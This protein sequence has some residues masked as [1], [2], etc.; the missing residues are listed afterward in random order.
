MIS[1][2]SILSDVELEARLARLVGRERAVATELLVHLAEFDAR[3]LYLGAGFS[4]LFTYCC[5]VL[6]LSE[7]EAY[8]RIE[9]ARAVRKFPQVLELLRDGSLSLT[10]ARM[11]A[12][13]LTHENAAALLE[14]ASGKSKRELEEVLAAQFPRPAVEASVR[15]L[16]AA[17]AVATLS[18]APPPAMPLDGGE[19]QPT[20]EAPEPVP[21]S[22][23]PAEVAP[24]SADQFLVKFTAS[25]CTREKLR[26]AQDLLR[27]T[28]PS[29]DVAQII[30][31]ALTLLLADL[32][33]KKVAA[34]DR[35][36][37]SKG[38]ARG[39]RHVPA[40]VK[41]GSWARDGGRCAFVGRT[42]RRCNERA[43]VEFHHVDPYVLDGTASLDGI[44]LRCRAHNQY[45][46]TLYFG[47]RLRDRAV[48]PERPDDSVGDNLRD[49]PSARG[50]VEI[51]HPHSADGAIG[52]AGAASPRPMA[53]VRR[54]VAANC[55][56]TADAAGT[57]DATTHHPL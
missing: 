29:G 10:T 26:Q 20:A 45:E 38:P 30:D 22:A 46:A 27:H 51:R 28:I 19:R 52:G 48:L 15:K 11:L 9:A 2:L 39:S 25:A 31:R 50:Y 44:G 14:L 24:L 49:T 7:G 56:D 34:T 35:P 4:S 16:P 21:R 13:H 41:R 53:R 57:A 18:I 8:N 40:K 23:R 3:R 6:R 42:G 55:G 1:A 54:R 5:G 32:A 12:S 43:F 47:P 36:R 37:S 17:S 33:R